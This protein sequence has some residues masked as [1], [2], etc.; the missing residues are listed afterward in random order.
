V[1]TVTQSL[2][3]RARSKVNAASQA[4]LGFWSTVPNASFVKRLDGRRTWVMIAR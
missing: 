2:S 1:P 4:Y 3:P